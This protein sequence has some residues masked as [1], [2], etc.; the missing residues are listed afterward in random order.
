MHDNENANLVLKLVCQAE[1]NQNNIVPPC[2]VF[3]VQNLC[4]FAACRAAMELYASLRE[5]LLGWEK[6]GSL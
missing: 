2:L 3:R 5:E 1:S 4:P 6:F